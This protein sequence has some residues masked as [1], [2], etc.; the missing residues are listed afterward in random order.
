MCLPVSYQLT[1]ILLFI[2]ILLLFIIIAS[3]SLSLLLLHYQKRSI[4][5]PVLKHTGLDS[6]DPLNFRP[7]ANVSFLSKI[8]EKIAAYQLTV[9]LEANKMLPEC[10]SGFRKGH[11]T[12]TLLLRLLSDIYL[13]YR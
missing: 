5:V 1:N 12:K 8:I 6:S 13:G 3:L 10:Q 9:Y 7:I 4:L 2:I 11:S